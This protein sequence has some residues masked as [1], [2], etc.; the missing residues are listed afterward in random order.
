M[1]WEYL[2]LTTVYFYLYVAVYLFQKLDIEIANLR[3]HSS[4]SKEAGS[5]QSQVLQTEYATMSKDPPNVCVDYTAVEKD[6][7]R[8]SN[9]H[10]KRTENDNTCN[11][12]MFRVTDEYAG[13]RFKSKQANDKQFSLLK[14]V[15]TTVT[16][17][18]N[19]IANNT[20]NINHNQAV[21][22]TGL[23]RDMV[24]ISFEALEQP[25]KHSETH[26]ERT[27][28][29]QTD[30]KEEPI[31]K[32]MIEINVNAGAEK[33]T[34]TTIQTDNCDDEHKRKRK[35]EHGKDN[36]RSKFKQTGN[37]KVNNTQLQ[38]ND[39]KQQEPLKEQSEKNERTKVA[40]TQLLSSTTD[41]QQQQLP[42]EEVKQKSKLNIQQPDKTE[43]SRLSESK[44]NT[45]QQE[46]LTDDNKQQSFA[47][48]ESAQLNFTATERQQMPTVRHKRHRKKHKKWSEDKIHLST[49]NQA[50]TAEKSQNRQQLNNE[51]KESHI[52]KPEEQQHQP[53]LAE[54]EQDI[55]IPDL[56]EEGVNNSLCTDAFDDKWEDCVSEDEN[57]TGI[58]AENI[59]VENQ[60]LAEG[61][62][63]KSAETKRYF[64]V[65][66][67]LSSALG[68]S[69]TYKEV[70]R[71]KKHRQ[72]KADIT[73]CMEDTDAEHVP[74]ITEPN[75]KSNITE[76]NSNITAPSK[77]SKAI[78]SVKN[79]KTDETPNENG[80]QLLTT[81]MGGSRVHP[82]HTHRFPVTRKGKTIYK[83]KTHW[84]DSKF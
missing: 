64:R 63:V 4:E 70:W 58:T 52:F 22:I 25:I 69:W 19:E 29:E 82:Y 21:P 54:K 80:T 28:I 61:K 7:E 49:H 72:L 32:K 47:G 33:G 40:D 79:T 14:D 53:R 17:P 26:S 68:Y 60:K 56:D 45:N 51:S 12:D 41:L 36:T 74:N 48:N 83:H 20:M 6:S 2:F 27:E 75:R 15:A 59:E 50:S 3:E 43:N 62:P 8:N 11:G 5:A 84:T 44:M 1:E 66:R 81:L 13:I 23:K 46:R 71:R 37:R 55:P 35:K 24:D 38:T 39:L 34:S 18:P 10:L 78:P 42:K 67:L 16:N 77:S 76:G 30:V 73:D 31:G 9:D 57:A 65:F